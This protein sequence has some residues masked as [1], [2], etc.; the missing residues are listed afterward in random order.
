MY[1][2]MPCNANGVATLDRMETMA[3]WYAQ[4]HGVRACYAMSLL[5]SSLAYLLPYVWTGDAKAERCVIGSA[6]LPVAAAWSAA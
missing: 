5:V 1:N 3:T 2:L 4:G 6:S